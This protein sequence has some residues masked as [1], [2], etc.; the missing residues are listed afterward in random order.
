MKQAHHDNNLLTRRFPLSVMIPPRRRHGGLNFNDR[1]PEY[2]AMMAQLRSARYATN[3]AVS[4]PPVPAGGG[5]S[6][7]SRVQ[8]FLNLRRNYDVQARNNFVRDVFLFAVIIAM[9]AW[10]VVHAVRAMGGP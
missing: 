3:R 4:P 5:D 8:P 10:A 6:R 1:S 2:R 7:V 9:S